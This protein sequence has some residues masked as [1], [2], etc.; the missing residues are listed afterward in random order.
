MIRDY[1]A[2][3]WNGLRFFVEVNL[4]FSFLLFLLSLIVGGHL[5]SIA[6]Q[7]SVV[8]FAISIV[9]FVFMKVAWWSL[10][11]SAWQKKFP[12]VKIESDDD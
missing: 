6:H 5:I 12:S 3:I 4:P 7:K 8:W 1:L 11:E 9:V 2:A 10:L